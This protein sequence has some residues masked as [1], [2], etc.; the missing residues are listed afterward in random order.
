M[1]LR[2][3]LSAGYPCDETGW[4]YAGTQNGYFLSFDWRKAPGSGQ[5]W[6]AFSLRDRDPESANRPQAP[7]FAT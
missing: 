4:P 1:R 7:E 5:F 3:R 2:N 6:P